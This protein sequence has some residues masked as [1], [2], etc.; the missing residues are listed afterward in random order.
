MILWFMGNDGSGKTSIIEQLKHKLQE[1]WYSVVVLWEFQT[2]IFWIIRKILR[3]DKK[4]LT[5]ETSY[6]PWY[7]Y[8]FIQCVDT[9]LQVLF[10]K[11]FLRWRI[12]LRDRTVE[13]YIV[14]M[15]EIGK[16]S[17]L[18]KWMYAM[19]PNMDM[20][21][22][23][24]VDPK[25]SWERRW[26]FKP[27]EVYQKKWELYKDLVQK[28]SNIITMSIR[29]IE[30]NTHRAFEKILL[31]RALQ[32]SV[33][34]QISGIDGAGKSTTIARLE[35]E[36]QQLNIWY[37]KIH[38]YYNYIILKIWK[39]ISQF[40]WKVEPTQEEKNKKSIQHEQKVKKNKKGIFW[41]IFV[42]SDA[43]I[44]YIW[45]NIIWWRKIKIY[46]R[47]FLD[48]KISWDFIGI[49]YS[50][51]I[52]SF[53]IWHP[54]YY[55][56]LIASPETLYKRKPEHTKQFFI[57]TVDSCKQEAKKFNLRMINTENTLPEWV[58]NIILHTLQL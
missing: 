8:L 51:A 30:E 54:E 17:F 44:Q 45:V 9:F 11:I 27:L 56:L 42:L 37:V 2:P 7:V 5:P 15:K 55:F 18:L 10:C 23:M 22:F 16:Y 25:D 46:D 24:E 3:S 57:E 43:Y 33:S 48:Y 47:Y 13:D 34:I 31:K 32:R 52:F 50:E 6:V 20:Y 4:E 29:P 41:K 36:L 21:F 39:R 35:K 49:P 26:H 58:K 1:Q 53:L 40:F 19:I 28:R 14:T 38:F 12:I